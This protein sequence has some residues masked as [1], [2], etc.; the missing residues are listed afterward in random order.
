MTDQ[1][2]ESLMHLVLQIIA[3]ISVLFASGGCAYL[4]LSIVAVARHLR[5]RPAVVDAARLQPFSILKP[6]RGCDRAMPEALRSF[7]R[8]HY[9]PGFELV[10]GV[11][12][13]DDEAVAEVERLR[14]EFPAIA[15]K[16]VHCEKQLGLNRKVSALEQMLAH[17]AH[18]WLLISDSDIRVAP[19]YLER[20]GARLAGDNVGLVTALYRA[21]AGS[22]L[23]SRI[24][25]LGVGTE[26]AAGV[27]L[28][29]WLSGG[30]RL[31]M[32][33]TIALSKTVLAEIGGFKPL[34]DWLADDNALGARVAEAGWRVELAD[35]AVETSLP[36]YGF[37]E[38]FEHQLR[39]SRTV[40]DLRPGGYFGSVV[41]FAL[42][43]AIFA[44][45]LSGG[46][47][48]AVILLMV[49]VLLRMSL[50]ALLAG[51]VLADRSSLKRLWLAPLRDL[52]GLGIWAASWCG[53]T[54]TW[55]GERFR[56]RRGRLEAL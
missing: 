24:E 41:T 31:A 32:G 49:T 33:S 47:R 48:W 29:G 20:L 22:T 39:W 1:S 17:C 3:V 46:E 11:A 37:R 7:C 55:R 44:V 6:L 26:F 10:F 2:F 27:L 45:L 53:H 43:W 56:L 25:A 12:A 4:L 13:M 36:D 8:Q 19:G 51:G 16:L 14:V 34:R 5:R 21:E 30:L 54:V 9:A 23:A 50:A 35:E 40:R 42:A 18:E 52:V 38:M 28:D 15:I